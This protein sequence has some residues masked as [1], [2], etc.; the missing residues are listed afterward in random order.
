MGRLSLPQQN[1]KKSIDRPAANATFFLQFERNASES[2]TYCW[3][4]RRPAHRRLVNCFWLNFLSQLLKRGSGTLVGPSNGFASWFNPFPLA[5]HLASSLSL[6]IA[7]PLLALT[8]LALTDCRRPPRRAA[9]FK[10]ENRAT[11]L[12]LTGESQKFACQRNGPHCQEGVL[13]SP[14]PNFFSFCI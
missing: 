1:G 13:F 8:R 11:Y 4:K 3:R 7:R 2:V 5:S 9:Q 6:S 10:K 12:T 14:L